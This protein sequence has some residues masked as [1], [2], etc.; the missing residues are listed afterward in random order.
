MHHA[1]CE[2]GRIEREAAELRKELAATTK[3]NLKLRD[4]LLE[5]RVDLDA[6]LKAL[7]VQRRVSLGLAGR[8]MANENEA[9]G[10]SGE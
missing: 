9:E 6:A 8:V 7:K 5:S 3:D 4:E 2:V 10:G 1:S